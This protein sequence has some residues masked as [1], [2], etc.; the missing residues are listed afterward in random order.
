[1]VWNREL[2]LFAQS[3]KKERLLPVLLCFSL[4][5]VFVLSFADTLLG[6]SMAKLPPPA[7]IT[8][9]G[10]NER[11]VLSWSPVATASTYHIYYATSPG[12]NKKNGKK[13]ADQHT[14]Y[15]LRNLANGTTYYFVVTSVNREGESE[16]SKEV[17]ATPVANPPPYAPTE[18]RAV[19]GDGKVTLSWLPSASGAK[20]YNIYYG[21]EP[22]VDKKKGI[23]I[24]DVTSPCDIAPL[25]NGVT[26]YFTVSAVN[27]NG[28]GA[29]SFEV[30]A[31]PRKSPPP[32]P[33]SAIS[34]V[35][36]DKRVTVSWESVKGAESY[37]LYYATDPFVSRK[38]GIKIAGVRSPHVVS[39]LKNN[40]EYF[41]V[42]TSVSKNGE[43]AE[44]Q[45]V[46][47]T[48]VAKRPKAEM[49][50]IPA[51]KFMMGDNLDNTSYALPYHSVYVSGF[52]IDKYETSYELW[53]EIYDWAVKHGYQFDNP[54]KKG[55]LSTGT[56]MPVTMVS[57][58]DAVKWLNARSEK[59]GRTP[60]YY[61][62]A[63]HRVVY[64]TGHVDLNNDAVKWDADG[65]RLP[66]EAEWEK[67]CRGGLEGKRYP[68]GDTI[69]TKKANYN[70]GRTT[71]LG[72][73][74]PNGYGLYDM[75][76]NVWEWVWDWATDDYNWVKDIADPRGPD[77]PLKAKMRVRRGGGWAYGERY[78]KC[79]ER[80]FRVPTY[81]GPYFGFRSVS[82]KK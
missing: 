38:T 79:F 31:T 15:T 73:Y 40:V 3:G 35:E 8:A 4:V 43:S 29:T 16:V 7:E 32:P 56:N 14:P 23:K 42:I 64:R 20:S 34:A 21:T 51:G 60:V 10:G 80:M 52:Y 76:G 71:S 66:T 39:G 67:A 82:V 62:D 48:P 75:A 58:Y 70:M 6:R 37:N 33:S 45:A 53:K 2:K 69:D 26:Y 78:L 81:V 36:G 41:F 54:G 12:V 57:W 22:G 46:S 47:A 1:M 72:S 50:F 44:S 61:T 59:E 5:L 55:S 49:I 28:E 25:R 74:P 18:V 24:P 17:A 77:A 65:Y 9:D 19:S 63:T 27:V 11:V 13:I 68:W 30:S